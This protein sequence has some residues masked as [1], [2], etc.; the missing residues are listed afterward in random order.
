LQTKAGTVPLH[1]K[2]TAPQVG[3]ATYCRECYVCSGCKKKL[4]G[5]FLPGAEPHTFVCQACHTCHKCAKSIAPGDEHL[6]FGAVRLHIK[7]LSC[8]KC[9]KLLPRAKIYRDS[10]GMP[11]C[12][13][14]NGA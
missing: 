4:A 1:A 12:E 14:H 6:V 13:A 2:L 8:S 9:G 11:A 7:C 3:D 5:T 10:A